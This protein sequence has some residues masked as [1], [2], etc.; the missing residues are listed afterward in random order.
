M[1]PIL[2]QPSSPAKAGDPLLRRQQA[3]EWAKAS[4][5][6]DGPPEAALRTSTAPDDTVGDGEP[7]G[8]AQLRL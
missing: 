1:G 7:L 2:F 3:L 4:G 6:R 8:A 5:P